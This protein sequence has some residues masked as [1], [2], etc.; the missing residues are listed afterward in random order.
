[1]FAKMKDKTKYTP[2]PKFP[3]AEFD[4]TVVVAES[5]KVG[6]ILQDGSRVTGRVKHILGDQKV[7]R[8]DG[9]LVTENHTVV[10]KLNQDDSEDNNDI[11]ELKDLDDM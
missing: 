9:V 8:L 11:N 6:D 10:L 5:I 4:C 3:G 1:M 7:Y 2:L